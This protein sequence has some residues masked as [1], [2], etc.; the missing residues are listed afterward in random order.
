MDGPISSSLQEIK[1]GGLVVVLNIIIG[2]LS[3]LFLLASSVKIF[4]VAKGHL[5]RSDAWRVLGP[6]TCY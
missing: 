4:G 5:A 1:Q 2:L 6:R 3:A